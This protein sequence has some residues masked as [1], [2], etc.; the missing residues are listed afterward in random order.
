MSIKHVLLGFLDWMPLSGYDLK[1]KMAEVPSHYWSGSNN[2]IYRTLVG[3]HRD[4]LASVA[5]EPQAEAP[6]RK[7]YA[8][9]EAGRS[10]LRQWLL[11]APPL[12]EI[13]NHFLIQLAWVEPLSDE[14]LDTLL[15]QYEEKLQI[16]ILMLAE[17]QRRGPLSPQRTRREAYLWDAIDARWRAFYENERDWVRQVRS[18]LRDL[19]PLEDAREAA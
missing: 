11:S 15:A 10:E 17:R 12:P 4:G 8:L 19:D 6:A 16:E 14:E 3:L 1:K 18:T 13:K 2:Q 7:V 5:I 9:T